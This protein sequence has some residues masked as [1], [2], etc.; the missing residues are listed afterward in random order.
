MPPG[1]NPLNLFRPAEP[2]SPVNSVVRKGS[3]VL[4]NY[5]GQTRHRIRDPHPLVLVA[6]IYADKV[7]GVN[8]HYLTLP[9]VKGLVLSAANN[10]RFSYSFVK[11]DSYIVDA[12]RSYK[13]SGISQMRVLD[14]A[15]LK[16]LLTVVR[17]LNPGEVEQI[18]KQVKAMLAEQTPQ[19]KAVPGPVPG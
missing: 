3:I 2:W 15:F 17:S 11:G 1:P 8:L 14:T 18:R 12:F 4:F 13:R 5:A 6:G 7:S 19:P 16:N 9:Y 10:P